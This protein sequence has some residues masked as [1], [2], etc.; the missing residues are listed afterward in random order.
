[1]QLGYIDTCPEIGY[2]AYIYDYDK[3]KKIQDKFCNEFWDKYRV[4]KANDPNNPIVEDVRYYFKRKS[5]S[6][7]QSINYPMK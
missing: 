4:L 7:R 6:E 5:A 2:R 1:M 3:L